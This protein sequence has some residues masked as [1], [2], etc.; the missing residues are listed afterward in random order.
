MAM[1]L[2]IAQ[3]A[4]TLVMAGVIWFVQVVHYPLFARVGSSEFAAYEAEHTTRTGWVVGPPMLVEIATA[5]LALV[6]GLRPEFFPPWAAVA[7]EAL[8]G[9]IWISTAAL[10]VPLHGRLV[11]GFDTRMAGRLV[12]SNW[13]RTVGWS[14]RAALLLWV[15][16]RVL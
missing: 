4:A 10:Q 3:I 7:G 12:S 2:F 15:V 16:A 11:A 5:T 8:V 9:V 1:E 14:L 6:P 13:V